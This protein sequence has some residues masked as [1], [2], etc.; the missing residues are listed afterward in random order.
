MNAVQETAR[1]LRSARTGAYHELSLVAPRIAQLTE[2]GQ[3]V[4]VRAAAPGTF[5]LRRPFSVHLADR[6]R[7]GLGT[8]SIVFEVTGP[9]T[10]ALA[11]ARVHDQLDLIGP[12][13]RAWTAPRAPAPCLLVGGGYG[14]APLFLLAER[15]RGAGCRVDMVLGAATATRLLKPVDAKR[16][17]AT[18]TL[19]TDDGSA[20]ARG[21]VTDVL[22]RGLARAGA[23]GGVVYACG[24]MAML[25]AVARAAA[26]AGV[27]CQVAVEERMACGTG[28]CYSCVV[29][30]VGGAMVRSCVD[31]PVFAGGTVAWAELGLGEPTDR[32]LVP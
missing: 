25:A 23:G 11:G 19:T 32:E 5:L 15:L 10:A 22:G 8:I 24:P 16:H 2:P 1:V 28:I 14:A 29:P 21:M 30:T 18:L 26:A 9:G 17:V 20:G 7:P 3:F 31:G 13:G 4:Q 12:L 27:P 6:T